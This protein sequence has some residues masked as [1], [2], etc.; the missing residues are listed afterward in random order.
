MN[1]G[2]ISLHRKLLKSPIFKDAH[3]VQLWVYLLLSVNHKDGEF[4][5][6]NTL[7]KIPKGS[8]LTGRKALAKSTGINEHKVD[9]LLKML[10]KCDQIEQQTFTRYLLISITNWDKY[11]DGEQQMSNDCATTEQRL[12]TNNNNTIINNNDNKKINST[13]KRFKPPT[14]S[15]VLAYIN[16]KQLTTVDGQAFLDFYDSK[17]WMVGKNKMK[18]WHSS[19]SGWHNRNIKNNTGVKNGHKKLTAVDRVRAANR[20]HLSPVSDT[21]PHCKVVGENDDDLWP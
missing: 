15:Q 11:Q 7:V 8:M 4:L 12:S 21:R 16:E 3:A 13:S 6:G 5:V 18:N 20:K 2:W 10:K 9:R 17:D 1:N 14:I 19:I